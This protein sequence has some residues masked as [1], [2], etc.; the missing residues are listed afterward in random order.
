MIIALRRRDMGWDEISKS[1]DGRTS[2][3]CRFRCVRY[4]KGKNRHEE[5]DKIARLYKKNIEC[6]AYS[7]ILAP[8]EAR[9][10]HTWLG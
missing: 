7:I 8:A 2:Q 6:Y 10:T 1:L 4:L 3:A 5:W 9:R